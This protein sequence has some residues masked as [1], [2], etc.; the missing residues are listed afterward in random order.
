MKPTR[1]LGLCFAAVLAGFVLVSLEQSIVARTLGW[2]VVLLGAAGC[3]LL[4]VGRIV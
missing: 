4:I 1:R 2:T 3:L